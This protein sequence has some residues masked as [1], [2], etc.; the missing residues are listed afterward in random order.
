MNEAKWRQFCEYWNAN[1]RAFGANDGASQWLEFITHDLTDLGTVRIALAPMAQR[2]A[3]QVEAGKYATLPTLAAVKKR[4]FE[5]IKQRK[6]ERQKAA[7][8]DTVCG[9]CRS[10]GLVYVLAPRKSDVERR[11]HWP[12]DFR[13]FDWQ[14]FAGF[15]TAR[16]PDCIGRD[17]F[18]HEASARIRR[19]S[20]PLLVDRSHDD[21]PA[22]VIGDVI[23]GDQAM[24]E[25]MR[26]NQ[27]KNVG[28]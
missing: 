25:I 20:M 27:S 22:W 3:Q 19:N 2:F 16:C 26:R 9:L 12:E 6:E 1:F 21:Y 23:G 24:S 4:Y 13:T 28:R 8:G 14:Y 5:L 10:A 11:E 7:Y 15:E 17:K 18:P